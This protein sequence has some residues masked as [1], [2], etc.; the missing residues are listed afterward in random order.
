MG[1]PHFL[2]GFCIKA[3]MGG[4]LGKLMEIEKLNSQA[5][6]NPA[7]DYIMCYMYSYIQYISNKN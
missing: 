2:N 5:P 7:L 3:K 6:Q 4:F 1:N